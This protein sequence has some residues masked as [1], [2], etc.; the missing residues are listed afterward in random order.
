M[1]GTL[2]VPPLKGEKS[3]AKKKEY[4]L[5]VLITFRDKYKPEVI[6]NKGEII[7]V[8]KERYEELINDPRGLVKGA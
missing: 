7:N 1:S 2:S 4:K 3:M 5:E 6:Y 8:S